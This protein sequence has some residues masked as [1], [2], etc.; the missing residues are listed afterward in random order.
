MAIRKYR[1]SVCEKVLGVLRRFGRGRSDNALMREIG[2][3]ACTY[4]DGARMLKAH[5][6]ALARG[7][8]EGLIEDAGPDGD[9]IAHSVIVKARQDVIRLGLATCNN[10]MMIRL[11]KRM[12]VKM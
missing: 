3:I 10:K 8:L 12:G 7:H 2:N 1:Y 9:M 6:D 11:M 4:Q 5:T